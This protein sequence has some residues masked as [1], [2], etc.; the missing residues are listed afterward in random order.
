MESASTRSQNR[1]NRLLIKKIEF[2]LFEARYKGLRKGNQIKME[3]EIGKGNR[4]RRWFEHFICT[5]RHEGKCVNQRKL[6]SVCWI[7]DTGWG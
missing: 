5:Q 6:I 7:H 4:V 1:T 2:L 3:A